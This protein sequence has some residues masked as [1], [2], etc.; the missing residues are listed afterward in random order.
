MTESEYEGLTEAATEALSEK[1]WVDLRSLAQRMVDDRPTDPIALSFLGIALFELGLSQRLPELVRQG[2]DYEVAAVRHGPDNSL[3]L[4]N[5][6]GSLLTLGDYRGAAAAFARAAQMQPD[7]PVLWGQ[8][9]QTELE[10]GRLRHADRSVR[11]VLRLTAGGEIRRFAIRKLFLSGGTQPLARCLY[12][13]A[14]RVKGAYV[15][16]EEAFG[17]RGVGASFQE[18]LV[19]LCEGMLALFAEYLDGGEPLSKAAQALAD[20]LRA[21]RDGQVPGESDGEGPFSDPRT[22]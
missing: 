7:N 9:A 18:A 16:S 8:L 2:I 11:Q 4:A 5:Y 14:S 17:L 3:V 22:G 10:L 15:C 21:Y 12:V 1:E 6:G 13:E 20:Q 19:D